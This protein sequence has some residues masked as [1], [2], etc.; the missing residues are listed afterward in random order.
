MWLLV[1]GLIFTVALTIGII[2]NLRFWPSLITIHRTEEDERLSPF[3]SVLIP[4]R[5]ESRNIRR[6][7]SSLQAQSYK[8]IEI[9]CLDD[10]SEDDTAEI[11]AQTASTDSRVKLMRGAELPVGWVGKSHACA[12]LAEAAKGDWL[13]F[14]DAD[15]VHSPDAIQR[16]V[17]TAMKRRADLLTG[18]PRILSNHA[19]G[20][21]VLPLMHFLIALHLPVFQVERSK[22]SMFMAAHGAFMLYRREAYEQ[23]GG[24]GALKHRNALVEDMTMAKAT[25]EAGYLVSLVDI[26]PIVAC[27]MYDQ[28]GQVWN[29][30][31]KNIY[32]GI[33]RST[34]LLFT[35][36]FFY[37]CLYVFP[38]V[39]FLILLS[40]G[41]LWLASLALGVVV[42]GML[43]KALVDRKFQVNGLWFL[44]ISISTCLLIAI[45]IRSWFLGITSR[46][47]EWKGRIYR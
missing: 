41:Q 26:S 44:G 18:F 33:G 37:F 1:A 10:R 19:L 20:Y 11:I 8:W 30:F 2:C 25:K 9:I 6:C 28:P 34:S 47:Y 3:V 15:T 38:I 16:A 17:I 12:Q 45:G 13:L 24:H 43:Q 36:F 39:I 5:N 42:L 4:A 22:K 32:N 27:E 23:I 29:G 40:Q 35:L 31:A 21:L 14:T 7:L 46:G